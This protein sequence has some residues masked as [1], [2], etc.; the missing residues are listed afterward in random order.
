MSLHGCVWTMA[1]SMC[2]LNGGNEMPSYGFTASGNVWCRGYV[3]AE[4][5]EGGIT[6]VK[7]K[8]IV[9]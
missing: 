3:T 7:G 9:E 2:S 5:K 6:E 4:N 8:C 1:E